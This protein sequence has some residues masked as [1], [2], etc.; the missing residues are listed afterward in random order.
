[1]TVTPSAP[2]W[3]VYAADRLVDRTSCPVCGTR[4]LVGSCCRRCGAD[5]ATPA[6]QE[7]WAAS[8]AAARALQHREEL[9]LLIP[10]AAAQP[11][12]SPP[13]TAEAAD[14]KQSRP[15][16]RRDGATSVQSVLAIAGA[17]LFAVAAVVFTFFNPDLG[18]ASARLL[19]TLGAS[20][21]LLLAARWL[22]AR[23]L[24]SSAETVGALGIVFVALDVYAFSALT[25]SGISPWVF[26]SLG[27]LVA[28]TVMIHLSLRWR[29]RAWFGPS[30]VGIAMTPAMFGTA[31][32]V[33]GPSIAG[34]ICT[35]AAALAL[36]MLARRSASRFDGTLTAER[37]ALTVV[38]LV[39]PL[40]TAT[41]LLPI[42]SVG[43]TV[44]AV[45]SAV[46]FAAVAIVARG[47]AG[48]IAPRWWS[49][50]FGASVALS[51]AAAA[52][53]TVT[54]ADA[55][56]G[57][58]LVALTVGPM[59]GF[60]AVSLI[61]PPSS[62]ARRRG[63]EIGALAVAL[64][65]LIPVA[66]SA[67][68]AGAATTFAAV[69]GRDS[70]LSPEAV[71]AAIGLAL[72]SLTLAAHA[73]LTR[74]RGVTLTSTL[75]AWVAGVALLAFTTLPSG[76]IWANITVGLGSA[77]IGGVLLARSPRRA[78]P[79]VRSPLLVAIHLAAIIA[80]A[81][82]W[83]TPATAVI[84]APAVAVAVLSLARTAS[85]SVRW[86]YLGSAYAYVLTASATGLALT[87]IGDIA[88][89]SLTTV[90][91]ALLAILATF[92]PRVG[93]RTWWAILAVTA[94]P[95]LFGIA[96]VVRERSGW[97]ALSTSLIFALALTLVFTRRS[98]LVPT[99]RAL[100]AAA[101]VPSLAVIVICLGAQF[102]TVSGSPVTLPVIAVIVAAALLGTDSGV[103]AIRSRGLDLGEARR[104]GWSFELS[105][106]VTAVI[107]VALAIGREAAGL[108]TAL[109]VLVILAAGAGCA[110]WLTTRRHLWW[111][112]GLSA[113][114]ALWVLAR[115]AGI[116]LVEAYILPP[117]LAAVTVGTVLVARGVGGR[118]LAT[119][120]MLA[121]PV[122]MVV[123]LASV[124]GHWRVWTLFVA[125]AA[126]ITVGRWL[127][128]SDR[129]PELHA[130]IIATAVVAAAAGPVQAV[131]LG[132]GLDA[133]TV[134]L[135]P[136]WV[137]LALSGIGGLLAGAAA[138]SVGARTEPQQPAP[139]MLA[140]LLSAAGA[141]YLVGGVWPAIHRDWATI[142][143]MWGLLLVV[144]A[145]MTAVGL[146]RTGRPSIAPPVWFLFVLAFVTAVVAWSPRDLRVEW[147]SLPLGAALLVI[148]AVRLSRV[149]TATSETMA[150]RT[151]LLARLGAWPFG[152]RGS[153]ALL[154][155]GLVVI[156]SASI[157]ATFTD[158]LTWRAI[159]VIVMAL[160]A[161]LVGA[162][163]RLAAPF[164]VG[165]IVLPL[166]NVSA[167]AV[168]IGRGI[169]S[170]PWWITLAAVGAVLLIL[171]VSYERRGDAVMAPRLRDLA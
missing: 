92:S 89:V 147:F 2:G 40:A 155:P 105:S 45:T 29:I 48:I 101:L 136:F 112:A 140:R 26:G 32:A 63:A 25:P 37:V 161:I 126:L 31:A 141:L 12:T 69:L 24:R 5:L 27:T 163:R 132:T 100:C 55:V 138:L 110:A 85:P 21:V 107:A 160:A 143:S 165:V 8:H 127:R 148:G 99:L 125:S 154:L 15:S 149:D 113:T 103:A 84:A 57:A 82:S 108:P 98:G 68:L 66:L 153:W 134:G 9:R 74:S 96:Q 52:V 86:L 60:V 75:A 124:G 13:P 104:V 58:A 129:L 106:L 90:C 64:A 114:G 77:A 47:T 166:E 121:A 67:A 72:T 93:V 115:M 157:L 50:V 162:W 28:S 130:S 30:A 65:L 73:R 135:A 117:S 131:R 7:L 51:F 171:A 22:A 6:A 41:Q 169:D 33:A 4:S 18:D 152:W 59:C 11:V 83:I 94:V 122:T 120:G 109:L 20:V 97:T 19:P 76:A 156:F 142:W 71:G 56:P 70:T 146:A 3:S 167:F 36:L 44:L 87:G 1:M 91:A 88:V 62:A 95:F 54:H 42:I 158:P 144:L 39:A 81:V 46:S 170:M 159:L 79:A 53:S 43:T 80:A 118:V 35:M 23:G 61:A 10:R 111:A 38:Q 78:R 128:R 116:E 34:W 139:A 17:G 16:D 119:C 14:A 102:L 145:A 164:V 168:Q 49:F 151:S 137:S 150:P 133:L 123:A